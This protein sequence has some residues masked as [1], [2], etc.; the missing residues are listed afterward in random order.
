MI[1]GSGEQLTEEEYLSF[2][3]VASS[4]ALV[5]YYIFNT[6]P[7]SISGLGDHLSPA[8]REAMLRIGGILELITTLA[9]KSEL[10]LDPQP[11]LTDDIANVEHDWRAVSFDRDVDCDEPCNEELTLEEIGLSPVNTDF[12]CWC[13]QK[14]S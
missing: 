10:H 12:R 9:F 4:D 3:S 6:T 2:C 14:N 8:A 11:L 1:A 5:C 7:S 13:L